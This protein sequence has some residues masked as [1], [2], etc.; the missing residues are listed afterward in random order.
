M[1]SPMVQSQ[2]YIKDKSNYSE[3]QVL[4]S[5]AGYYVGTLFTT[6]EGWEEPGSR[7]SGY[8]KTKDEA[9]SYLKMVSRAA[10]PQEYLRDEP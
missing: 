8:F 7:D 6:P 5:A 9:G 10:N 2:P 3:L 1:K 4:K